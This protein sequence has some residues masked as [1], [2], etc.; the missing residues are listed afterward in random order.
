MDMYQAQIRRIPN[1]DV[2]MRYGTMTVRQC[3][4]AVRYILWRY[5]NNVI[6]CASALTVLCLDGT[7]T[8]TVCCCCDSMELLRYCV[9]GIEM[10]L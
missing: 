9:S 3:E 1:G 10:M 4:G 7:V 8:C 2:K 6:G 5:G